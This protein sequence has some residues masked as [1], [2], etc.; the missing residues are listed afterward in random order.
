M[1]KKEYF[2][3]TVQLVEMKVSDILLISLSEGDNF[4]DDSWFDED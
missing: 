3:P 2:C 1:I 4:I